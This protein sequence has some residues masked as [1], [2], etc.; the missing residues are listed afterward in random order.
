MI[1]SSIPLQLKD[2]VRFSIWKFKK[3]LV[4]IFLVMDFIVLKQKTTLGSNS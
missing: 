1:D 4:N 3:K 2:H